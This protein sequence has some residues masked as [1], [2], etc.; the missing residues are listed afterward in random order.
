MKKFQK[1]DEKLSKRLIIHKT[2]LLEELEKE[3]KEIEAAAKSRKFKKDVHEKAERAGEILLGLLLLGGIVTIAAIAPNM[4]SA[5]GHLTKR[6]TFIEKREFLKTKKYLK[7][8]GLIQLN[9]EGKNG[10]EIA[11]TE[12]GTKR[13]LNYV[14]RKLKV[15]HQKKWDGYWRIV[16]FDIPRKENWARN[17][18]REKLKE[19]G[20]YKLQNSVFIFPYPCDR[21]LGYLISVFNI[22]SYVHIIQA[23]NVS[24]DRTLRHH[25]QLERFA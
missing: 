23:K 25:F 14:F 20:F 10:Y 7:R 9:V 18:F 13:I 16:I 6:R 17:G 12:K 21:E 4:F 5:F 11:I 8:Q 24:I 1:R 3:W 22:A 19:L 2:L 15:A